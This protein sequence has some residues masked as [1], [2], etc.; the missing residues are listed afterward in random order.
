MRLSVFQDVFH[1]DPI[2]QEIGDYRPF[3][4]RGRLKFLHAGLK[5]V[6]KGGKVGFFVSQNPVD[7][8][9][10]GVLDHLKAFL[11]PSDVIPASSLVSF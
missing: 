7:Q 3:P 10:N 2:N 9:L 1:P 6:E 5:V 8:A 4:L 11:F